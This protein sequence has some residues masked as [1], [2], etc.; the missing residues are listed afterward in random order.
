MVADK[1]I[2]SMS[3]IFREVNA[4]VDGLT[5]MDVNSNKEHIWISY[6]LE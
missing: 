6:L 1:F 3:H 5:N 4:L 2:I